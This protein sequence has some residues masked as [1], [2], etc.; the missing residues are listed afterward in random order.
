MAQDKWKVTRLVVQN[1]QT[2]R[3]IDFKPQG[4]NRGS[5][6]R[7]TAVGVIGPCPSAQFI[8]SHL[9]R[10]AADPSPVRSRLGAER[11]P[12]FASHAN[13]NSLLPSQESALGS[14]P[15]PRARLSRR[16]WRARIG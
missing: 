5:V 9:P 4:S 6:A 15:I 13:P 2:I 7:I 16:C 1:Y 3:C 12:R 14:F 11:D 8:R 10:V